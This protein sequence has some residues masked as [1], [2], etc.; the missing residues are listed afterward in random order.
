MTTRIVPTG[1][2]LPSSTRIWATRPAA[3]DGISTV[4]LSVWISTSGWSSVTSSP[5]AT[6]QRATSP[7]VRPSPRSGSLN[8]YATAPNLS[9]ATDPGIGGGD[10]HAQAAFDA[11]ERHG[12]LVA[13]QLGRHLTRDVAGLERPLL[14]PDGD[15][16]RIVLVGRLGDERD[17]KAGIERRV[18][19]RLGPEG[20]ARHG[21]HSHTLVLPA[22][23]LAGRRVSQSKPRARALEQQ[24]QTVAQ[25]SAE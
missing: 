6:S 20:D 14:V 19:V 11:P 4:V 9:R 8:S 17:R 12:L 10:Q 2:T 1:T 3:G 18:F 23:D 22:H 13:G 21:H 5:T 25:S 24:T 7:S 15:R 16:V